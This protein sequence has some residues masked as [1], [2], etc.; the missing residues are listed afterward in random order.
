MK[1]IRLV[2]S[3]VHLQQLF[4]FPVVVVFKYSLTCPVSAYAYRE[5]I[6]FVT[7]HPATPVYGIPVQTHRPVATYLEK[8]TGVRHESPQV[9]VLY[10]GKVAAVASHGK[11]T[12]GF[13]TSEAGSE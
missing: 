11:V 4:N 3:T 13:L 2:D 10:K 1:P 9:F 8:Y 6:Y 12:A 7:T 5:V